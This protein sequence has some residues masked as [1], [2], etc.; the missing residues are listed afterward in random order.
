M[1]PAP[2]ARSRRALSPPAGKRRERSERIAIVRWRRVD[3]CSAAVALTSHQAGADHC[4]QTRSGVMM[5]Q[6][7]AISGGRSRSSVLPRRAS[8]RSVR[9]G[10]ERLR[11]D[12]ARHEEGPCSSWARS[13]SCHDRKSDVMRTV[14][15]T[16]PV[17][18]RLAQVP[19][20]SC[21]SGCVGFSSSVIG[22]ATRFAGPKSLKDLGISGHE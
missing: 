7:Q 22:P 6:R 3:E 18:L 13:T 9:R 20:D 21:R 14:K 17:D 10:S 16:T 5:L 2:V 8:R 15:I 11:T 4:F 12:L 19:L 1:R